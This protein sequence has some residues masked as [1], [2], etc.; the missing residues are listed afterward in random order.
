MVWDHEGHRE[1]EVGNFDLL[2]K[3][4][5]KVTRPQSSIPRHE[6]YIVY[7]AENRDTIFALRD[8]GHTTAC[9]SSAI[10]TEHPRLFIVTDPQSLASFKYNTLDLTNM[11]MNAY[12]NNKLMY[13]STKT[14][15]NMNNMY[16]LLI[17]QQCE[18]ERNEL[19][20]T[21]SIAKTDL[22]EFAYKT[23][24]GPGYSAAYIGEIIYLYQCVPVD[25]ELRESNHCFN[26]LQVQ[27]NNQSCYMAPKTHILQSYGSE[28]PCNPMLPAGF[29]L[30]NQ[31]YSFSPKLGLLK[32]PQTL[33]PRSSWVW[34][35]ES[36]HALM[37]AGIHS[38]KSMDEFQ[39]H[40]LFPQEVIAAEKNIARESM[41]YPSYDQGLHLPTG[42]NDATISNMIERK[43]QHMWGWFTVIGTYTSG[44]LGIFV[45]CKLVLMVFNALVNGALLYK[46]FGFGFE[47]CGAVCGAITNFLLHNEHMKSAT[48]SDDTKP[49]NDGYQ[50]KPKKIDQDRRLYPSLDPVSLTQQW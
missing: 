28:I 4:S 16:R 45:V 18:L 43:L 30:G 20:I 36:P 5:I 22:Q 24:K 47:L 19:R 50:P 8:D 42:I 26:E 48:K 17:E 34:N 37:T 11:D 29:K 49:S 31:W 1:C 2:Y 14:E 25:V 3:D 40:L 9:G 23:G 41:G 6:E 38:Q 35:Y 12:I 44:L 39:K 21:L 27:H 46:A 15:E 13:L 33:A 7:V 10:A 32:E